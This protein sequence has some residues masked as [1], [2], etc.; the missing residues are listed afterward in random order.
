MVAEGCRYLELFHPIHDILKLKGI[1]MIFCCFAVIFSK[2]FPE[3]SSFRLFFFFV[4]I[5]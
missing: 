1:N 2:I 4:N 5:H 3:L